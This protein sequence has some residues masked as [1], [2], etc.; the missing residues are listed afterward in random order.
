MIWIWIWIWIYIKKIIIYKYNVSCRVQSL[1]QINNI[2]RKRTN[3]YC[4]SLWFIPILLFFINRHQDLISLFTPLINSTTTNNNNF[5]VLFLKLIIYI[6]SF[7]F[8]ET[9]VYTE[10]K[11]YVQIYLNIWLE[12]VKLGENKKVRFF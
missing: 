10:I 9:W 5:I 12:S 11:Q 1:K 8:S 7:I 4:H 6:I 2:N 3:I